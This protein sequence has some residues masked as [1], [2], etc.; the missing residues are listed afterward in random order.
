MAVSF[1]T[2]AATST[3]RAKLRSIG[4]RVDRGR[5]GVGLRVLLL[6]RGREVA[7]GGERIL[8]MQLLGLGLLAL[9]VVHGCELAGGGERVRVL[10]APHPLPRR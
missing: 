8:G 3:A 10:L 6:A 9:T 7:G 2:S 5:T 4:L 1:A